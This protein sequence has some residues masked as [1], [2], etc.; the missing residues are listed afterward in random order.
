M[1]EINS[2]LILNT[3][4]DCDILPST[5][6]DIFLKKDAINPIS[7][8][9]ITRVTL[10]KDLILSV[11]SYKFSRNAVV[12]SSLTKPSKLKFYN[13]IRFR[14]GYDFKKSIEMRISDLNGMDVSDI[15]PNVK[16]EK[17][18]DDTF[19]KVIRMFI[20]K[21]GSSLSNQMDSSWYTDTFKDQLMSIAKRLAPSCN[22]VSYLAG[23][24][25]GY[26][27]YRPTLTKTVNYNNT[28]RKI[29][30]FNQNK[31]ILFWLEFTSNKDD[32]II[33]LANAG[34]P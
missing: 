29:E 30:V 7:S 6:N 4:F 27:Y 21:Q 16:Y 28:V 26:F 34:A 20:E 32:D 23:C 11:H 17:F 22:S 19:I 10:P 1:P 15:T 18:N 3:D 5:A 9:G 33:L 13:S 2:K 31:N 12:S 14:Y 24:L 8:N 25:D